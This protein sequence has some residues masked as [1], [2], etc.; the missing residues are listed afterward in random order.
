MWTMV[1]GLECYGPFG[2][3]LTSKHKQEHLLFTKRGEK[4]LPVAILKKNKQK[5]KHSINL[6]TK[7]NRSKTKNE[8]F[9]LHNGTT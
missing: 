8:V 5:K 4:N 2:S 1:K 3:F 7:D 9:W 6:E